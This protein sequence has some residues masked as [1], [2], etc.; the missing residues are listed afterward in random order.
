MPFRRK[1]K[2]S[3]K[4][5]KTYQKLEDMTSVSLWERTFE[6]RKQTLMKKGKELELACG[7]IVSILLIEKFVLC[8]FFYTEMKSCLIF[9]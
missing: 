1:R 7:V 6:N 5:K 4:S 2:I 9:Y 8:G 3:A